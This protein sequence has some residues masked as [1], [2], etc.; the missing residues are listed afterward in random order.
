[1]IF[2]A[3]NRFDEENYFLT[4]IDTSVPNCEVTGELDGVPVSFFGDV[5]EG[6]IIGGTVEWNQ[7]IKNGNFDP[8][9]PNTEWDSTNGTL[10][11]ENEMGSVIQTEMT[12]A[13]V[14]IFQTIPGFS[15]IPGHKYLYSVSVKSPTWADTGNAIV[16]AIS[17]LWVK[18]LTASQLLTD[19]WNDLAGI[20]KR[21]E[22]A[23]YKFDVRKY[24]EDSP[25]P[26]MIKNPM[27]FDL[28]QMF[29]S[30]IADYIYSLE[31]ANAGSGV[32]LFKTL[33]APDDYY[34][35]DS[36]TE[37]TITLR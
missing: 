28:T 18:P 5:E 1:M 7:F 14:S 8:S 17:G 2:R 27:V 22:I 11:L 30:T 21:D 23:P 9:L 13:Y 6:L 37:K 24:K 31:Q 36:G 29:G 10:T 15:F 12:Q 34:K 35:Y 25:T 3:G 16:L 26:L 33:F 4:E 32:T 20:M 19:A